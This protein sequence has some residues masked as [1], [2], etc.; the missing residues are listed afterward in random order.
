MMNIFDELNDDNFEI[1]AIRN[2]NNPQCLSVEEFHE[3]VAR[4]KYIQRLLRR[5]RNNGD[6][7]ERLI[8]NHLIA[9][10]NIFPIQAANRMMFH[11]IDKELWPALKTF[12]TFLN[13]LPTD[14]LEDIPGDLLIAKKLKEL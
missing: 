10:Y 4:F 12:L 2:Y 8:L 7:K 6:L 11:R 5:Y 1:F 3:D 9:I 14:V 13:Y